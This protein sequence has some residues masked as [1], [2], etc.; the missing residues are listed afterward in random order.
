MIAVL[1][2]KNETCI[3]LPVQGQ[4]P[5]ILWI[6]LN[7]STV[8]E[9]GLSAFQ[10]SVLG[11][12]LICSMQNHDTV[13]KV[14]KLFDFRK[15]WVICHFFI[16]GVTKMELLGIIFELQG[17]ERSYV[18]GPRLKEDSFNDILK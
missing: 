4:S 14:Y 1:D 17:L 7:T 11:H 15:S 16:L 3:P 18:I 2:G 8:W 6:R 13:M 10:L 9:L 5:P 12:G